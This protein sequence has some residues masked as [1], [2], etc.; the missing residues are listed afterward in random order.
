MSWSEQQ[1]CFA[2]MV[3][4]QCYVHSYVVQ[5]FSLVL[6][7]SQWLGTPAGDKAALYVGGAGLIARSGPTS[8]EAAGGLEVRATMLASLLVH[9]YVYAQPNPI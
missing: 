7:S 8:G 9:V 6:H 3:R 2:K 5:Y 4:T 1:R